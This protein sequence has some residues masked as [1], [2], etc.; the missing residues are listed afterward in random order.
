MRKMQSQGKL[1]DKLDEIVKKLTIE[2]FVVHNFCWITS[3]YIK[4]NLR[5]LPK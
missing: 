4:Q 2:N 1:A 5:N 3:N